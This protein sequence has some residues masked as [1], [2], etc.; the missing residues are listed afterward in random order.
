MLLLLLL[1]LNMAQKSGNFRIGLLPWLFLSQIICIMF[2]GKF[3]VKAGM[4]RKNSKHLC[5]DM[6]EF[7]SALFC[8]IL[9]KQILQGS[10]YVPSFDHGVGD[11]VKMWSTHQHF[12]NFWHKLWYIL[13]KSKWW[14]M[15][16]NIK[17]ETLSS[18]GQAR[19]NE[20]QILHHYNMLVSIFEFV[21]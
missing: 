7:L 6:M 4:H 10:V 8:C 13:N 15:I 12:I 5:T 2:M 14:N 21:M 1:L 19:G 11:P 3:C 17:T 16:Q 9:V 18:W 20:I